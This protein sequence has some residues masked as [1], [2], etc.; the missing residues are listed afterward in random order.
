MK[1]ECLEHGIVRY[2]TPLYIFDIDEVQKTVQ[3]YRHLSGNKAGLCYAMKANPF[4]VNQM[5]TVVDRIEVCSMGEFQICKECQI[6][7]EKILISGVLKRRED[8]YQVLEYYRGTCTYT[9]ES[10]SQFQYFADWSEEN[11]EVIP[12]YLRLTSGNQ[13]GMDKKT[14]RNMIAVRRMCPFLKIQGIHYFSGTLKKN[15]ENIKKELEYLD[16]FCKELEEETGFQIEE[17]EYGPGISVPYFEGQKDTI[18]D[19]WKAMIEAITRMQWTGSVMLELG[20]ALVASCGYYLTSVQ[21]VKQNGEKNYCIV[22]GGIHQINYDGQIRGM[23]KPHFRVSPEHDGEK[24][25]IWTVCGSLCTANDILIQAAEIKGLKI[26]NVLIFERVGA[27]SVTEGMALF[28]SHELPKVAFY[29]KEMGWK[30][31]RGERQTYEDNMEK[32]IDD[33]AFDEYFNRVR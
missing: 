27:Y 32:E 25:E 12:V 7:P 8:I 5:E 28:L 31:V 6:P 11:H 4:L 18:E 9:V 19:D 22:D 23:Y 26:D 33:E 14:I 16:Q 10:M 21:D 24:A 1:M 2:G 13:F 30:L 17:L 29:S 15:I 20:R 3:E